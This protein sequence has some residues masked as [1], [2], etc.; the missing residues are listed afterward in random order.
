MIHLE[1]KFGIR[2]STE[3]IDFIEQEVLP[4]TNITAEKFWTGLARIIR[5]LTPTNKELLQKRT[6]FQKQINEW[7]RASKHR[8]FNFVEY[9]RFYTQLATLYQNRSRSR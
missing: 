9:K 6:Y 4:Q 5:E 3:F 1:E 7:H 2:I 8:E